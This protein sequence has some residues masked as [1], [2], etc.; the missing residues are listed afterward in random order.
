M[1]DDNVFLVGGFKD[2]NKTIAV[3]SDD[4][5]YFFP[6]S[7]FANIKKMDT[8]V[9]HSTQEDNGITRSIIIIITEN[10]ISNANS[11]N[12]SI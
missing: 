4:N 12:S 11:A 1:I 5:K 3:Y 9:Y 2:N 8:G 6:K 7:Y 10:I